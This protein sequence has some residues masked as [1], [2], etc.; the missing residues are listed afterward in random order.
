ML[1][2]LLKNF[3]YFHFGLFSPVPINITAALTHICGSNCKTCNIPRHKPKGKILTAFEWQKIF[4]N[5]GS[6]YG[7]VIFT[8]GEPFLHPQLP[9]IAQAATKHSKLKAIIIPTNGLYPQKVLTKTKKILRTCPKNTKIIINLSIDGIGKDHDHLRGVPGN[10]QKAKKTWRVLKKIRAKNLELKIHTVISRFNV[11][12]IPQ[13][14]EGLR[15]E[16]DSPDIITEIAEER[17]EM[18]NLNQNITPSQKDYAKAIEVVKTYVRSSNPEGLNRLVQAF[19]LTYYDAVKD[20]LM[21]N[22][23]NFPCYAAVSSLQIAPNADVWSCCIKAKVI[24]NLRESSYS[25]KKILSSKKAQKERQK[26]KER[27]CS[28]PLANTAYSNMLL[29]HPSLLRTLQGYFF[30]GQVL[31]I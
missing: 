4:K 22:N 7:E 14:L 20:N 10:Y 28:C 24:G 5:L 31:Q 3:L 8:G 26:I 15:K 19:R 27:T 1:I 17:Q 18:H 12:K 11:K 23:D 6:T 21:S 25:L 2:N 13:V 30:V 29:N 16:F 9:Q